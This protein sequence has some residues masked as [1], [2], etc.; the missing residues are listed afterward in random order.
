M[1]YTAHVQVPDAAIGAVLHDVVLGQD[2]VTCSTLRSSGNGTWLS[3]GFHAE[4]D[5]AASMTASAIR[6]NAS[7]V[8][9]ELVVPVGYEA[10]SVR[11]FEGA[12]MIVT[13]GRVVVYS[14]GV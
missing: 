11:S 2:E 6:F 12:P 1:E 4:G 13:Q 8:P 14:E 3:I 7:R 10:D 5:D 9:E